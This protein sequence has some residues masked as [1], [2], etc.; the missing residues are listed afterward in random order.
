MNGR[1]GNLRRVEPKCLGQ[2]QR[3]E[4][5]VLHQGVK[6]LACCRLKHLSKDH[7]TAVRIVPVGARREKTRRR[8]ADVDKVLRAPCGERIGEE[9]LNKSHFIRHMIGIARRHIGQHPHCRKIAAGKVR[10]PAFYRR[11]KI[12]QILLC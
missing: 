8:Q 7:I 2:L 3:P 12:E 10:E 1:F 6:G 5:V 11:V 9:R 4:D